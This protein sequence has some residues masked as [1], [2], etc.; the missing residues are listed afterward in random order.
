MKI[1]Q[2]GENVLVFG[3]VA[4]LRGEIALLVPY[5]LLTFMFAL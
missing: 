4:V 2:K 3:I 5:L 1:A